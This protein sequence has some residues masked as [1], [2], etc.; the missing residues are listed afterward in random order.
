MHANYS[1]EPIR[2]YATKQEID[3]YPC[4]LGLTRIAEIGVTISIIAW[5]SPIIG[6]S[7]AMMDHWRKSGNDGDG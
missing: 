5:L 4:R 3:Q 2:M 1:I 7:Q 6:E